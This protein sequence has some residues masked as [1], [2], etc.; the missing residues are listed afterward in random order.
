MVTCL[1]GPKTLIMPIQGL[2]SCRS[3]T[4]GNLSSKGQV[5]NHPV[6]GADIIVVKGLVLLLNVWIKRSCRSVCKSVG[7]IHELPLRVGE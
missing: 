7:V 1:S 5:R 4:Y 3:S 6:T 2:T